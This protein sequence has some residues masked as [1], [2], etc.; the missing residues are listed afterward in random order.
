MSKTKILLGI[1]WAITAINT[2]FVVTM[3][4]LYA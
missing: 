1:L 4:S 2:S 3:L